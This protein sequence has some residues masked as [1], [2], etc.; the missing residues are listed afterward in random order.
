MPINVDPA[1]IKNTREPGKSLQIV[2]S[3]EDLDAISDSL[4]T[5]SDWDGSTVLL[6][7]DTDEE[8]GSAIGQIHREGLNELNFVTTEVGPRYKFT[9]AGDFL[10]HT[11]F[12]HFSTVYKFS[13]IEPSGDK[14]VTFTV[15]S[16][17]WTGPI[18]TEVSRVL[19]MD[20]ILIGGSTL[21]GFFYRL[22]W[23]GDINLPLLTP[24]TFGTIYYV[25]IVIQTVVDFASRQTEVSPVINSRAFVFAS[26]DDC[27]L[28]TSTLDLGAVPTAD[29][30]FSVDDTKESGA[31]IVYTI[32]GGNVDP[33]TTDLGVVADGDTITGFQF[34]LPTASF[35]SI[36][37][38]RGILQRISVASAELNFIVNHPVSDLNK[39]RV[40]LLPAPLK[41]ISTKLD[42]EKPASIGETGI[43]M[44][45]SAWLGGI[46]H[47][48][49][50]RGKNVAIDLGYD[51][52]LFSQFAPFFRGTWYD[53]TADHVK[54]FIN[55]QLRNVLDQWRKVKLPKETS[56]S[57]GVKTT[58]PII[59]TDE[60]IFSVMLDLFDRIGFPDRFIART[61][62]ET[63]RDETFPFTDFNVTRTI[64][65]PIE[66]F[67]LLNELSVISGVFLVPYADGRIFPIIYDPNAAEAAVFDA[68]FMD[69]G[70]IKGG[71]KDL[72]TRQ[73]IYFNPS[74]AEPK[75]DEDDFSS[76]FIDLDA[77][78]ETLW[79]ESNEKR[80]FEKWDLSIVLVAA[81]ANRWHSWFAN[82]KKI[83]QVTKAN[84][85]FIEVQPGDIVH[86]DNLH[87]PVTQADFPGFSESIHCL[88]LDRSLD[89]KGSLSYSMVEV[90]ETQ[91]CFVTSVNAIVGTTI[92]IVSNMQVK[93]ETYFQIE[94]VTNTPGFQVEF[95]VTHNDNVL[96]EFVFWGRYEGNPA[97]NIKIQVWEVGATIPAWIDLRVGVSD[98]PNST[99]DYFLRLPFFFTPSFFSDNGN[100]TFNVLF[101]IIHSSA[102]SNTH[103]FYIDQFFVR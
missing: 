17:S 39:A 96:R 4:D 23:N 29:I 53:Y 2:V 11:H 61:E 54:G 63:L 47:D 86:V 97:H 38:R 101:R 98:F 52:M 27:N 74:V 5:K 90:E 36:S 45:W 64:T 76:L 94:E 60:N 34:Y 44:A 48:E 9:A 3:I 50:L 57:D 77:T 35:S 69:F 6:N 49:F 19:H 30:I 59:Y 81:L 15:R 31:D 1:F 66:A 8:D 71:Y 93:D 28:T 46:I 21:Q 37:G 75:D 80:W 92:G 102:G 89:P 85:G 55:V 24:M 26:G 22:Q 83:F 12:S 43:S 32:L 41:E 10:N 33:P 18:L 58:Q 84:L 87:I 20:N 68:N 72:F 67:K 99:T 25:N 7:I 51:N 65:K 79:E 95:N 78:V 40:L 62:F 91:Q 70:I 103:D 73:L 14:L 13:P 100:G 56:D 42:R 16:D 88:I 82:P